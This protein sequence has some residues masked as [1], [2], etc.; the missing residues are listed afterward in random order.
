MYTKK[1][2]LKSIK[3]NAIA[4]SIDLEFVHY[5]EDEQG[6]VD[7][8][9]MKGEGY[10]C[11]CGNEDM[12]KEKLGVQDG[13]LVDFMNAVWAD[14]VVAAYQAKKVEQEAILSDADEQNDLIQESAS[15]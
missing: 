9:S 15:K 1:R 6:N 13:P 4:N 5:F 14:E 11:E 3:Y 7:K 8:G 2:V 12:V 10:A